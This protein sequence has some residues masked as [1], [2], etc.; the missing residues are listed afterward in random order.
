MTTV[1][2]T[3][4]EPPTEDLALTDRQRAPR[5]GVTVVTPQRM[6]PRRDTPWGAALAST[7]LAILSILMLGFVAELSILGNLKNHRDQATAY[8]DVRGALA[9]GVVPVSAFAD[10][11]TLV[12]PGTPLG[13]IQFP[14]LGVQ[15]VFFQGTSSRVTQSGPGHL[16]TTVM[17]GQ[18]GIS[19]LQGRQS[20]Y[21]GAF[22][23]LVELRQ[24]DAVF[25]AT[26]QGR[27]EYRV[28]AV[29]HKGDPMPKPLAEG[30]A[31][32]AMITAD[33]PEYAPTGAVVVDAALVAG[34]DGGKDPYPAGATVATA[35]LSGAD[36][37]M[38][39]DTDAMVPIILWSQLLL[40]AALGL[41]WTTR[42][43]GLLQTWIVGV[44][45]IGI[46]ALSLADEIARLL[47]NLL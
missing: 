21:G 44:P 37:A 33:G 25:V 14:T 20:G 24:G 38:A 40:L 36:K 28:S 18:M 4:T 17:P 6:R 7:S 10:D 12:Q 3:R 39:T 15:Q 1:T 26:G 34:Q 16:M 27:S 31:R 19:V 32:L 11:G 46:V 30:K 8:D 9:N 42:R 43:W 35:A 5:E 29:R 23:R 13:V 22:A 47:P 45:L 2:P 41:S